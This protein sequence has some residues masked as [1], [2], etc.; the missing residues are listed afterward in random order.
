MSFPC[1]I[2]GS[3]PKQNAR[4]IRDIKAADKL[5]SDKRNAKNACRPDVDADQEAVK[6][7]ISFL[8]KFDTGLA[9]PLATTPILSAVH[10]LAQG[11]AE[12]GVPGGIKQAADDLA[13]GTITGDCDFLQNAL[14]N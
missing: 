7:L 4:I 12:K 9:T 10:G 14:I 8:L 13:E 11:S 6:E 1:I 3:N 5:A 2:L